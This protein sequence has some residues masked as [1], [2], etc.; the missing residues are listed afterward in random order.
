MNKLIFTFQVWG[1]VWMLVTLLSYTIRWTG[2][3]LPLFAQTFVISTIM[4]PAMIF[5]IMPI[6]NKADRK[7]QHLS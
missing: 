1:C 5:I 7:S 2:I 3:Q 4:V 6:I